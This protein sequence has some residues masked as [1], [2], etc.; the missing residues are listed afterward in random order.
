MAAVGANS[1]EISCATW[2]IR[3]L[4]GKPIVWLA[5]GLIAT[6]WVAIVALLPFAWS[7]PSGYGES[8]AYEVAFLG[9]LAGAVL[10]V[11]AV[12]EAS[13]LLGRASPWRRQRARWA[14]IGTAGL[15]GAGAALAAPLLLGVAAD[16]RRGTG[17]LLGLGVLTAQGAALAGLPVSRGT[18]SLALPLLAWVVPGVLTPVTGPPGLFTAWLDAS[19]WIDLSRTPGWA[20]CLCALGPIVMWAF[21]P[22]VLA[23]SSSPRSRALDALRHPR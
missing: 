18:R 9:G 11:D 10:G 4:A 16:P 20:P 21:L 15:L 6:G 8:L 23:P 2:G 5:T 13:W 7:A 14:V 17:L 22:L 1:L 19:L 3:R 12:G